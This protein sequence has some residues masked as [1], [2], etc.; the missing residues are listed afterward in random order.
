[1]PMNVPSPPST[2]MTSQCARQLVARA[3][4]PA[5]R[6]PGERRGFG[7]ED[8]ADVAGLEPA[9]Q[10][11]EHAGRRVEAALRDQPDAG[12]G[13]GAHGS[14]SIRRFIVLARGE[15]GGRTRG[16]LRR[17]RSAT[18]ISPTRINP[19]SLAAAATSSITRACTAA[20]RTRPPLPTSSRP[21]SN[22]GFTSAT[23]S[24]L[25][26]SSG[27]SAGQD[28]PQRDERDVDRHEIEDARV[29]GS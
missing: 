5:R 25:G 4:R 15:G 20:S 9:R 27:G 12:H 16:C 8:R 23:M 26:R 24:P 17:L 22:C 28:L 3:R 21:A 18:A 2:T 1:M 6:Q 13:S 14:F 29:D 19:S 11:G 7:L 10:L